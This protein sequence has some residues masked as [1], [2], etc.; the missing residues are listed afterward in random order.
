MVASILCSLYVVD[1]HVSIVRSVL[2]RKTIN[3]DNELDG[4]FT[5]VILIL[6]VCTASFWASIIFYL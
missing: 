1:L 6:F 3:G 4:G 2:L 5:Y